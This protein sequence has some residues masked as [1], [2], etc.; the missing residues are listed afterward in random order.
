MFMS[1]LFMPTSSGTPMAY[2]KGL[3]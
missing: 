3:V 1:F 2:N